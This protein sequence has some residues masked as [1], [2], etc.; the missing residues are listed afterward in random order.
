MGESSLAHP[1]F[2]D[3]KHLSLKHQTN[4]KNNTKHLLFINE[5]MKHFKG[6]IVNWKDF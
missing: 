6:S 5:D 1:G 3:T 4:N 2:V